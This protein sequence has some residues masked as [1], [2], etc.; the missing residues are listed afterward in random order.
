MKSNKNQRPY[1][2]TLLELMVTTAML[3]AITTSSVV[4]MRTSYTAW[5]RHEHDHAQ[6]QAGLAVLRH[7]TRQARQMKS[8]MAISAPTDNSG[9]LSLLSTD[10]K[11][12]VW[13]HNSS[14]KQ[15]LFGQNTASHVL[16]TGIEEL[17]F[18]GVKADGTTQT[19]KRG[20]IHSINC[21]TKVNITRPTGIESV[22]SSCR[23]WIRAW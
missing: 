20:L 15:V 1:G 2:F 14:T 8:V 17:T 13:D 22:V 16:A 18:V 21:T 10:G 9:S 5:N 12:W 23:A 11:L 7:I 3:A 4:L 6:R 19:T